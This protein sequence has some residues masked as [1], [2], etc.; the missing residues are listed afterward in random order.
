MK[1]GGTKSGGAKLL[2]MGAGARGK[3]SSTGPS[4]GLGMGQGSSAGGGPTN[5]EKKKLNAS[6]IQPGTPVGVLP[7]EE[8]AP[9][10]D[11][12]LPVVGASPEA[13][14]KMAEKVDTEVLPAEVREQVLKYMDLLRKPAG[15]SGGEATG[16]AAAGEGEAAGAGGTPAEGN[17]E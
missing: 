2:G 3:S 15:G 4:P 7:S 16:G 11:A 5:L 10:G 12:Q 17:G 8:P 14:R 9:R 6:G 1:S 13:L